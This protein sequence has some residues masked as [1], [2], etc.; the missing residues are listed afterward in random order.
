MS[1]GRKAITIESVNAI[2]AKVGVGTFVQ[3]LQDHK[4]KTLKDIRVGLFGITAGAV[5]L[6]EDKIAKL[7]S[8]GIESGVVPADLKA[9]GK[10]KSVGNGGQRGRKS[11]AEVLKAQFGKGLVEVLD[12]VAPNAKTAKTAAR[13]LSNATNGEVEV[14]DLVLK[15]NLAKIQGLTGKYAEWL[16]KKREPKGVAA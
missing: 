12:E 4:D 5:T 10:V 8:E 2:M 14:S 6:S 1:K 15:L 9:F 3:Y 13:L 7:V 11:L 16:P